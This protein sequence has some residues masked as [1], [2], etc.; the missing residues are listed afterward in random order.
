MVKK[1]TVSTVGLM[2]GILLSFASSSKL[3]HDMPEQLISS[4]KVYTPTEEGQNSFSI[5]ERGTSYQQIIKTMGRYPD[6][7]DWTGPTSC[8]LIY[9]NVCII[10]I[11]KYIE[12]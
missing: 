5:K 11:C 9:H 12:I 1:I 4:K 3:E 8:D 6:T 2:L 10:G 7:E